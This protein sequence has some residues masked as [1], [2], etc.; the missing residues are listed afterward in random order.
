MGVSSPN[1]SCKNEIRAPTG[2]V[3]EFRVD[4]STR[5]FFLVPESV[6]SK[7]DD[8]KS[9][10]LCTLNPLHVSAIPFYPN[11]KAS[12]KHASTK[13]ACTPASL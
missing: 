7:I 4:W 6:L 11:H 9:N 5:T 8:N 3:F 12:T 13:V 1:K 2:S 10:K